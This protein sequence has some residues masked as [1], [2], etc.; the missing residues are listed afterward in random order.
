MLFAESSSQLD[1]SRL[2]TLF[3]AVVQIRQNII[4]S[5]YNWIT[6]YYFIGITWYNHQ[7]IFIISLYHISQ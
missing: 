1:A 6:I 3:S 5:L 2:V 7:V 4:I